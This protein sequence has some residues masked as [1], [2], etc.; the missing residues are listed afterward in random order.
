MLIGHR[1]R[2]LGT[3]G[4]QPLPSA[5]AV[6]LPTV[7][8]AHRGERMQELLGDQPLPERRRDYLP[9]GVGARYSWPLLILVSA[10]SGSLGGS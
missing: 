3:H 4:R 2:V 1:R 9:W 5:L 6:L 10:V 8:P 7:R